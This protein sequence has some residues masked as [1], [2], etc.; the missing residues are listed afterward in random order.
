MFG[1]CHH[2]QMMIVTMKVMMMEA[3]VQHNDYGYAMLYVQRLDHLQE[4]ANKLKYRL[5]FVHLWVGRA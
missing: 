1:L 5:L 3:F 2:I 4:S